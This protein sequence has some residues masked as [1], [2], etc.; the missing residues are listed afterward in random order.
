M[1]LHKS[2]SQLSISRL[3]A[4]GTAFQPL[5]TAVQTAVS[6]AGGSGIYYVYTE[7]VRGKA[8]HQLR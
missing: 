3:A 4:M 8:K 7:I 6:G 5:T 1:C 2:K